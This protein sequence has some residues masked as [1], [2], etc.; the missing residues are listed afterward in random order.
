MGDLRS[1]RVLGSGDPS[2]AVCSGQETQAQL[3]NHFFSLSVGG[4][5]AIESSKVLGATLP[6]FHASK[7]NVTFALPS[8][9]SSGTRT[10]P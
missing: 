2:T 8:L 7:D 6:C 9:A 3:C 4:G 10:G 5:L 1:V